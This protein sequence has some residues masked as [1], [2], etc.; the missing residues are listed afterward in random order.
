VVTL[1]PLLVRLGAGLPGTFWWLWAGALVSAL[2]TFVFPF[3]ALFLRS[4]GFSAEE[5]G[6]T[7]ALFGA[8]T[9]VSGPVAGHLADRVGRR[10]TML[11]ALCCTGAL[12]ALLA[13]LSSP[14]AVAAA[15]L[16]LGLTSNAYRPAAS[17]TIADVVPGPARP[18]AFGLLYWAHNLGVGISFAAGGLLAASG[19]GPL[20]LADA[21]T[22]LAFALLVWRRVPE[23]RPAAAAAQADGPGFGAVLGDG[24]FLAF[25]GLHLLLLLVFL[26]F[27]VAAPLDMAAR[28]LSTAT[29]GRVLAVN[30]LLIVLLQ[31]VL[32]RW[33]GRLD[34]SRALALAALLMGLG[35]G[36]YG[37]ARG[38]WGLAGATAV[39]TLG[40]ILMAPVGSAVVAALAPAALRGRYQGIFSL[41]WGLGMLLA[42]PLGA[43][44]LARAGAGALWAGC[45]ALALTVA[46]GHL[47]AGG[48]RR[49]RMAGGA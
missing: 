21:G 46:A 41:S 12:T 20:F 4:R 25:L 42:P 16:A 33:A 13:G 14:A 22:T 39:W 38:A 1:R 7:V 2:A 18:R 15:V 44:V 17:A 36:G 24:V 40:E 6:L 49:R 19:W 30:G 11:F 29:Y 31:P 28:G 32:I 8:G 9:V 3:L 35:F 5:T 37:M 34:P 43:S 26:Q 27:M 23:T 47:A 10:P 45:L 48:A